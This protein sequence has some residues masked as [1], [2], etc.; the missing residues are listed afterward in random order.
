[1][2][3][4]G[5][6]QDQL[7]LPWSYDAPSPVLREFHA[8]GAVPH[9]VVVGHEGG[10]DIKGRYIREDMNGM[11]REEEVTVAT[12]HNPAIAQYILNAVREYSGTHLGTKQEMN[13]LAMDFLSEKRNWERKF[14]EA[15][16][17]RK[18]LE[19]RLAAAQEVI[20]KAEEKEAARKALALKEFK[21]TESR[22]I[23]IRKD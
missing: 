14:K 5:S 4:H 3:W 13:N 6:V 11:I 22:R 23:R 1:M 12:C 16:Q 21:K 7:M 19:V 2:N 10:L 17:E 15:E 20:R 9:R 18:T 8:L